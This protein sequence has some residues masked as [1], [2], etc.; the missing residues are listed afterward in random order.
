MH[1]LVTTDTVGG[2]WTYTRELVTGLIAQGDRVTLISFGGKPTH[3]QCV[4]MD[5]LSALT[6][7]D[8]DYPL[9]WM[10]DS[11][12][13]IAESTIFL[14]RVIAQTKPDLL[15]FSQYCYG[16]LSTTTPK[17]VVA[18]SDVVSWWKT[19][20]ESPP[21]DSSWFRWY[22]KVVKCG[23]E[24][25]DVVVAPSK[26]MLT[27]LLGEY[28]PVRDARVIHNG[29]TAA[30]FNPFGEKEDMVVSA[31]RI[32]DKGKNVSLLTSHEQMVPIC[33]AGATA[34]NADDPHKPDE[35][36]NNGRITSLGTLCERELSTLLSKS[37]IYAA[38]SKYEPF[39]LAPLEAAL[40]G[41]ALVMNDIPVFRELWQNHAVFFRRD[42]AADL[43][44]S[45]ALLS[46]SP[47]L[48]DVYAKRAYDHAMKHFT[49]ARMIEDYSSLFRELLVGAAA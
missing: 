49:T 28:G 5:T 40:S 25:A 2:V 30:L 6:F 10:D 8:T 44:R 29:R 18:H 24:Q 35:L 47:V 41:C 17:V 7:I 39:G 37:S 3:E 34:R 13:G 4:W 36:Q 22:R 9:E 33:I 15:H 46:G 23:L 19:V 42:D 38:T 14:R 27:T 11:E 1:V 12:D 16:S 21:P 26:W 48:R 43:A 32:W 45:I 20:H 31:G